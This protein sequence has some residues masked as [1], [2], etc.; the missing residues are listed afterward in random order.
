M[1]SGVFSESSMVMRKIVYTTSVSYFDRD[2]ERKNMY[3]MYIISC[4]KCINFRTICTFLL[5]G[6]ALNLFV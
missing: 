2:S 4:K 5:G 1:H 6:G 3:T